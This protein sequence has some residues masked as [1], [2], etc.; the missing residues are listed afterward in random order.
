MLEITLFWE[1]KNWKGRGYANNIWLHIYPEKKEYYMYT[2]PYCNIASENVVEVMRKSDIKDM[3][4][5]LES[6]GFSRQLNS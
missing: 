1:D 2:T 4:A 5:Y 6:M 3:V